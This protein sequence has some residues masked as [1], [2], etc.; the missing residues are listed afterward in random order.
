MDELCKGITK[1]GEKCKYKCKFGMYCGKHNVEKR[2]SKE[3]KS[4]KESKHNFDGIDL[5]RLPERLK[6]KLANSSDIG[7]KTL[8]EQIIQMWL[9]DGGS[10]SI[11]Q[12]YGNRIPVAEDVY[13]LLLKEFNDEEFVMD[14]IF[15]TEH[16]SKNDSEVIYGSSRVPLVPTSLH[17]Y[18]DF[19]P[20][21]FVTSLTKEQQESFISLRTFIFKKW[22]GLGEIIHNNKI[23]LNKGIY[24]GAKKYIKTKLQ[25]VNDLYTIN[26]DFWTDYIM[27]NIFEI[28]KDKDEFKNT[29]QKTFKKTKV[30]KP[31]P[32]KYVSKN[33]TIKNIE[34]ELNKIFPDKNVKVYIDIITK[35]TRDYKINSNADIYKLYKEFHP[36]KC[37]SDQKTVKLC[38]LFCGRVENIKKLWNN[39][40]NPGLASPIS[41]KFAETELLLKILNNEL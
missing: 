40:K 5:P 38:N 36:D 6:E 20:Q 3:S 32:I 8:K 25:E 4:P 11:L 28:G 41:S 12:K 33:V 10:Y 29:W 18:S 34:S 21:F 31:E 30:V 23:Y 19:I 13:I 2:Q 1:K 35:N 14:R 9:E 17:Y 22:N 39:K 27:T 7:I 37:D 26:I 15:T 24:D 16:R